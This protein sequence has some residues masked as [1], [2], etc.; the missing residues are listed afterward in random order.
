MIRIANRGSFVA[1]SAI[2]LALSVGIAAAGATIATPAFAAKKDSGA[3]K[4]QFSKGFLP[5][6]QAAQKAVEQAKA[7]DAA[8]IAAAKSSID[9]AFAA[10]ESN[11]DR[12]MA[13][14]FAVNLGGK[15]Q[16]PAL[17]RRGVKAMIES[18]KADAATL[19]KLQSAAGQ[20]AY[21]AKAYPEAVTYLEPLATSGNADANTMAILAEAYM[22]SN[23][24][25][26]GLGIFESAIKQ[27][28]SSGTLAPESWYRRALSAAYNAKN[29]AR[30]SDLGGLLIRDY[31]TPAN[32]GLATTIVR[33]LG[34]WNAQDTLDL[35]RLMGRTKSF[36]EQRDYVEYIQAADPRRL[37]GETLD[38]INAGL[39]S[40]KLNASDTFVSD[41]K[42]QAQ[43]RLSADKASLSGYLADARKSG[44][45]EATINGAADALLSY[46][47]AGEA[48]TLYASALSKPGVDTARTLTRLGI[49]QIDQ[50]KFA[51]AQQTFAKV[52]GPRAPIAKLWAA[53]AASKSSG[54]AA[55]A[56]APIS[57]AT[58]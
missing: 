12:F 24:L 9:A 26:K 37:P 5:A 11:D 47:R 31:P 56:A 49:A 58:P 25:D 10:A 40:G 36:V 50:G 7:G 53:Y 14:Q 32:V 41:A 3:S 35:M 52:T 8:T 45:S 43:G 6:A 27:G 18:G 13:G 15:A 16:D 1:R 21:Q 23:Q 33:E 51:P 4:L 39:A 34:R 20:L 55:A 29:L 2:G 30:A 46:G 22:A 19:P 57:P 44:A 38:V 54:G 28:K 48:E 42:S 17:Q